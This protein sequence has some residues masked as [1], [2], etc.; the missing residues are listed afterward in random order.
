MPHREIGV[1]F[2]TFDLLTALERVA[3]T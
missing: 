2:Q 3:Q 1:V